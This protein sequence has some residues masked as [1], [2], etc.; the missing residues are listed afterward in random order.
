MI[1]EAEERPQ[2]GLA[3]SAALLSAGNIGSRVLG[4]VREMVIAY[5]FGTTGYVS[6]FRSV[7]RTLRLLYDL[8]VGGM[9][10]AALVPV[11]SEYAAR[12]DKTALWQA[13]SAI[14]TL[15]TLLLAVVALAVS[16]GAVPIIHLLIPGLDPIYQAAGVRMLRL[17][18]WAILFFGVSGLLTGLLFTLQRFTFPAFTTAVFNLG[19]VLT[20]P[21]LV[22]RFD[23]YSLAIGT[24]VGSLSQTLLLMPGLLDARIRPIWEPLHPALVKVWKL[25][26]PLLAGLLVGQAQVLIDTNLASRTGQH[27][28]AWM[29]NATTLREL[30]LGL[31]SMAISAAV[32]PRLSQNIASGDT[33]QYRQTLGYVLRLVIL[34]TIPAAVGLAVFAK[35]LIRILFQRGVFTASDTRWTALALWGYLPGLFFASIDW[36]I[37]YSFYARQDTKT[38]TLVGIAAVLAYLVVALALLHPLGMLGL[39]IADSS[40]HAFHAITMSVLL[41]LWLRPV[42]GKSVFLALGR[43]LLAAAAMAAVGLLLSAWLKGAFGVGMIGS[44]VEVVFGG[45]IALAMYFSLLLVLGD[46]DTRQLWVRMWSKFFPFLE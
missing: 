41:Y 39:V 45:S 24:V 19:V 33:G 7:N 40:K 37:N 25:Y 36:P 18:S 3:R 43:S 23:V 16:A 21:L 11:L 14:L 29:Q 28:L 1:D 4:L 9:M 20:V 30:P 15:F 32:L 13:F 31:I 10:S 42:R 38:P 46:T 6:A 2:P 26:L 12:R 34:L 5:Y 22:G 44:F 27:S 8:L 17:M 35:P